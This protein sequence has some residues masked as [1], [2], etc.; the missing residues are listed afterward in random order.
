MHKNAPKHIIVDFNTVVNFSTALILA[1]I[2]FST[3]MIIIYVVSHQ[4]IRFTTLWLMLDITLLLKFVSLV[5]F[6]FVCLY[7]HSSSRLNL[8]GLI[9]H[10]VQHK[11][12]HLPV[13]AQTI[14]TPWAILLQSHQQ[15]IPLPVLYLVL[16]TSRF[17]HLHAFPA[18]WQPSSHV[19]HLP[20]ATHASQ[21]S[22]LHI[23]IVCLYVSTHHS[24]CCS[25]TSARH[26]HT[27]RSPLWSCSD[28][29]HMFTWSDMRHALRH[30]PCLHPH[31]PQLSS[32]HCSSNI[33]GWNSLCS[34]VVPCKLS[35]PTKK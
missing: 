34:N 23:V 31:V 32:P 3:A 9:S 20:H 14:Q 4:W 17:P 22:Y 5:R 15:S 18:S 33:V 19:C 16:D 7:S 6:D 28:T 12:R 27:H 35:L 21:H 24:A 13:P 2:N 26:S 11:L 29:H 1:C 8:D 30:A 10:S 25:C